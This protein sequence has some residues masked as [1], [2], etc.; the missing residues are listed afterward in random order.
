MKE[1]NNVLNLNVK[2]GNSENRRKRETN[3]EFVDQS[4]AEY[5]GLLSQKEASNYDKLLSTT[6]TEELNKLLSDQISIVKHTAPLLNNVWNRLHGEIETVKDTFGSLR[7]GATF[8][9]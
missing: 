6:F 3:V 5:T 9:N 7:S 2:S 4:A 8:E 1:V